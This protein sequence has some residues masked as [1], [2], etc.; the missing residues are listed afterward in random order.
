MAANSLFNTYFP[1]LDHV[2]VQHYLTISFASRMTLSRSSVGS[3]ER[4]G[5]LRRALLDD[6]DDDGGVGSGR[7][8]GIDTA[9]VGDANRSGD[10][11][12]IKFPSR[13]S[14]GG[15]L[16]N[17][18]SVWTFRQHKTTLFASW[19]HY[20]LWLSFDGVRL[21]SFFFGLICKLVGA[22]TSA[23]FSVGGWGLSDW[24]GRMIALLPDTA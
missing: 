3:G 15:L 1:F 19:N 9:G 10:A 24:G 4:P 18:K 11:V 23:V 6:V 22:S 13:R 14:S 20:L 7:L 2:E 8:D 5:C 17:L 12:D 16:S 21:M